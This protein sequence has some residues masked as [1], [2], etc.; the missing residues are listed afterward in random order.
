MKK[1]TFNLMRG[2]SL[3]LIWAISLCLSA[4]NLTVTGLVSDT[5]GEPLIGVTVQVRGTTNGT[6]TDIDGRFA[7]S[8]VPTNAVL[9]VSY[10][11]MQAQSIQ[12]NGKTSAKTSNT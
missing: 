5:G 11:G 12:L 3:V 2:A 1:R 4:Q 7:L 10:V 6:V 9:D 8:N